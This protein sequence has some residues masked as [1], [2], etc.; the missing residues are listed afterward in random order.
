[1]STNKKGAPSGGSAG[2]TPFLAGA[3]QAGDLVTF[4]VGLEEHGQNNELCLGGGGGGAGGNLVLAENLA[5]GILAR[6]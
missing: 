6:K 3:G 5:V 4:Q 1:M 2:A